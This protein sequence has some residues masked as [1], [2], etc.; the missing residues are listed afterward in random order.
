MHSV[1]AQFEQAGNNVGAVERFP[2]VQ[3]YAKAAAQMQSDAVEVVHAIA[4]PE[5]HVF[6]HKDGACC[7]RHE[8]SC[9][10]A[11]HHF[12]SSWDCLRDYTDRIDERAP[13]LLQSTRLGGVDEFEQGTLVELAWLVT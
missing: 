3:I 12:G 13:D 2:A 11:H 1:I 7:W 10:R 4:L 6:L 8:T 5:T 9:W